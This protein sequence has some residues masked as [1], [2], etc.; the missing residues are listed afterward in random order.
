MGR[1]DFQKFL[2]SSFCHLSPFIVSRFRHPISALLQLMYLVSLERTRLKTCLPG[3]S[4]A[5]GASAKCAAE[6]STG[7]G[8]RVPV[9]HSL[10]QACS[11]GRAASRSLHTPAW[12][13]QVRGEKQRAIWTIKRTER[14]RVV[15][16]WQ[17]ACAAVGHQQN[18]FLK[19][20]LIVFAFST[21]TSDRIERRTEHFRHGMCNVTFGR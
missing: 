13:A 18:G 14:Q 7:V 20:S 2:F 12:H 1:H 4:A 17:K 11:T 15:R 21:N 16:R 3:R 6:P 8:H 10:Q 19:R 5:H 9:L